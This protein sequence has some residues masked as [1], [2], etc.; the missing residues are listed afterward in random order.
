MT[1]WVAKNQA[2]EETPIRERCSVA[3][4]L[5]TRD[6]PDISVAKC[7][8]KP[9]VITELHALKDA[10]ELY[11]MLSGT[12]RV[13]DGENPPLDV[14]PDDVV[15]ISPNW[16]QRIENTGDDDLV[17]LAICTERFQPERYIVLEEL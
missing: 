4:L 17:F 15:V 2:V 16:P 1:L 12:G 13:D 8:V 10:Q 6:K 3:E 14:G 7:R 9:G 5:N 11:V